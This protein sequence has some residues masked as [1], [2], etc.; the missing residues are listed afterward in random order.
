MSSLD[1]ELKAASER[2]MQKQ[3]VQSDVGMAEGITGAALQGLTLGFS[4][5]IGAGVSAGIQ[6]LFSDKSFGDIFDT[7]VAASRNKLETFKKHS[8]KLH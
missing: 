5:E 3:T 6:S 7:R 8:Q 1:N 2:L 4:D